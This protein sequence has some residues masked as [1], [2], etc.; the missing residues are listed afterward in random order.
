M[1]DIVAVG[2]IAKQLEFLIPEVL[3]FVRSVSQSNF[4]PLSTST[5]LPL[6]FSRSSIESIGNMPAPQGSIK[7]LVCSSLGG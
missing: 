3:T 7:A 6:P 5:N 2:A 1:L 4:V